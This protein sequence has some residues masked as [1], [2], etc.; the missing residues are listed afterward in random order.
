[1]VRLGDVRCSTVGS[2]ALRSCFIG[3]DSPIAMRSGDMRFGPLKRG[4][5]TSGCLWRPM[6]LS[7]WLMCGVPSMARFP[8]SNTVG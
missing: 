5:V 8:N 6:V 3:E 7:G 1:M 4:E 2:G